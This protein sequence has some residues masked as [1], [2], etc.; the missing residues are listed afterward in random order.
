TSLEL[1]SYNAMHAMDYMMYAY[2]QR[3]QDQAAKQLLDEVRVIQK[4][5]APNFPAAF[6]LAAMS[7]RY[8]LERRRW[9]EAA[10]LKLHPQDLPW[11]QFPQAEAQLVFARALG[12]ARTGDIAGAQLEVQ[13]LQTLQAKLK[14]MKIGYWAQQ[15]QIQV[16]AAS[17]MLAFSQGKS[18]EA[19]Q[20]MRFAVELEEATDKHPVTPGPLV[21]ARELLGE[22]L[23]ELNRPAEAA[24]EFM[25]TQKTDPNRFRA[26][27]S[28]ALATELAG[29]RQ[30]ARAMYEQLMALTE[31]RDTERP[32]LARVRAFLSGG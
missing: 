24:A 21:P 11:G 25:R 1:G 27:Y 13:R 9:D 23:L 19:L 5:D 4:L 30:M 3:G 14:E 28:A 6:A 10:Q 18:D 15:V 7:A 8:A 2:L 12:A 20:T 26:I 32:E 29:D 22:M 31:Q 16:T 17:A